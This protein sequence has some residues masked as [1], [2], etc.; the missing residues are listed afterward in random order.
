MIG[1]SLQ[2][3]GAVLPGT[4]RPLAQLR[5]VVENPR[6]I[7]VD[8][9]DHLIAPNGQ[10]LINFEAKHKPVGAVI[11]FGEKVTDTEWFEF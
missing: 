1:K 11:G 6:A 2:A 3:L 5:I 8:L 7:L 9:G 4:D 10:L